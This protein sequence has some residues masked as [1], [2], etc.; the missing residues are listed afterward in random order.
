MAIT[1]PGMR[2]ASMSAFSVALI[3]ASRSLESPTSSGLARGKGSSAKAVPEASRQSAVARI[4]MA[5]MD[6]S[7]SGSSALD[8]YEGRLG[9]RYRRGQQGIHSFS[10][11]QPFSP[12]RFL[13]AFMQCHSR[14]AVGG[15]FAVPDGVLALLAAIIY[16]AQGAVGLQYKSILAGLFEPGEEDTQIQHA[17][18]GNL[19]GHHFAFIGG[20]AEVA[21]VYDPV[22][23]SNLIGKHRAFAPVGSNRT[24]QRP[25]SNQSPCACRLGYRIRGR[26][27]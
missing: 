21:P 16:R 27:E 18:S 9:Q 26:V 5:V 11:G 24:V 8:L 10:W 12:R 17:I 15:E 22:T 20:I 13:H 2:P 4:L 3:R 14:V 25:G 1:A 7:R 19:G 6:V 23:G